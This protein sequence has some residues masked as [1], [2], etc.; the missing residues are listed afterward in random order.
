MPG[1]YDALYERIQQ[2]FDVEKIT[3]KNISDFIKSKKG[4]RDLLVKEIVTAF[5][6]AR[7]QKFAERKNITLSD[8]ITAKDESW[9]DKKDRIVLRD[10]RGRFVRWEVQI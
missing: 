10:N 5:S 8:K 4:N 6:V 2:E 9:K 7:F 3:K 1:G